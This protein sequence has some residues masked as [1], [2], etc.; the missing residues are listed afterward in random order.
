MSK[1]ARIENEDEY[2]ISEESAQKAVRE[3][4]DFYEIDTT[5]DDKEQEKVL[6][7]YLDSFMKAY[8]RGNFE[9]KQD[10]DHGF[11]VVQHLKNGDKLTYRELRG[12]DRIVMEG[13]DNTRPYS[14][15]YAILGK[16]SGHGEDV[17]KKLKGKDWKD[18]EAL[19][20]VFFMV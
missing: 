8:R 4:L 15:A 17:I 7:G 2:K 18:A 12:K 20:M 14:R 9:N 16:L 1:W 19:A 3:V 13:F 11:C 10:E 6:D 5:R